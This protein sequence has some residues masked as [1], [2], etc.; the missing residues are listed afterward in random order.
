MTSKRVF[1]LIVG[2]PLALVSLPI[3]ITVGLAISFIDGPP[4]LLRQ[5]RVGARQIPFVMFKFRTMATGVPVV[6]KSALA[7]D[8]ALYTRL[9]PALRRSSLDELPQIINV[10]IGNM[11]LVGPRPALPSQHDLLELR[12]RKGVEVLQPGMTG[13]AQ[14]KGR[15]ALTLS[16]KTRLEALYLRRR[17]AGLDLLIMVWTLRALFASRG[18]Y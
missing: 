6:A 15:E 7:S 14:V 5:S 9:G 18:A 16:S 12:R 8:Q 17:S 1:D 3:L 10:L 11:S 4:L 13:L 2:V